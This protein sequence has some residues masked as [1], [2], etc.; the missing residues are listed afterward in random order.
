[1]SIPGLVAL[2]VTALVLPACQQGASEP[3]PLEGAAIGGPINLTD[4]NGKPFLD[5][6]LAGKY[7][8]IYFGYTWCPDIC[9]TDMQQLALALRQFEKDHAA[10]AAKVQPLFITVDPQR[11]TPPKLAQFVAAFHPRFI[12][13]TGSVEQ[14]AAV[15]KAYA[16]PVLKGDV[17]ATGNYLVNH[18]RMTFLMDPQGKPIA[19][20]TP[21]K[22]AATVV[23]DLETWVK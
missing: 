14:I 15:T 13:L 18:G 6:T 4:M 12:G 17:D 19:L 2:A 16:I 23:A 7:R 1:M 20:L 3:P 8:L 22:G 10:L 5:A 21:D 9:P 11:D